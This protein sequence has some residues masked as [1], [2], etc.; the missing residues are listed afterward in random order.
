MVKHEYE[1][2]EIF[3]SFQGEGLF[4]GLPCVFVRLAGCNLKCD[5]CDTDHMV[6]KK[7]TMQ[8][9]EEEIISLVPDISFVVF[10]G[11]EPLLQLKEDDPCKIPDCSFNVETNGT[12]SKIP[13]W[14]HHVT[15]SPKIVGIYCEADEYKILADENFEGH[16][17]LLK[18]KPN[19]QVQPLD[20]NNKMNW[21]EA[22]ELAWKYKLAISFQVHKLI[23]AR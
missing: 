2:C 23:G 11:G 15:C 17:Q 8:E 18:D 10:T 20:F 9:I 12:V 22:L 16:Y 19:V 6:S 14:I 7:L 5:F 1:I 4:T 13:S 21:E 3:K